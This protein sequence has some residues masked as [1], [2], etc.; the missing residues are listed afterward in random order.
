MLTPSL[1]YPAARW[2]S[3]V[4]ML[5]NSSWAIARLPLPAAASSQTWRWR[6]VSD[7]APSSAAWRGRRPD[8]H[9]LAPRALGEQDRADRVGVGQRGPQCVARLDPPAER[10]PGRCRAPAAARTASSRAACR[11]PRRARARRARRAPSCVGLG[12]GAGVQRGGDRDGRAEALGQRQLGVGERERPRR[13]ARGAPA[14]S[15]AVERHGVHVGFGRPCSSRSAPASQ[16]LGEARSKSPSASHSR[17]RAWRTPIS[18]PAARARRRARARAA[19]RAPRRTRR[20]RPARRRAPGR[21]AGE[22]R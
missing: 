18:Q 19:A 7:A 11:R 2:V 4:L 3:T 5:R 17:A 13:G 15:A 9:Q 21:A 16:R 14:R 8:R 22:A 20:A 1:R 6:G 10:T 12:D